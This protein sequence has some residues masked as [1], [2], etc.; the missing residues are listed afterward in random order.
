MATIVVFHSALGLT[1]GTREWAAA[2]AAR[3]AAAGHTVTTPDL[4]EGRTFADVDEAVEFVDGYGLPHWVRVAADA[5]A[6]LTGPRIYVGF[7]FGAA[8][9]QVLALTNPDAAGLVLLSGAMAPSWFEIETWPA[10]L[11]GELHYATLDPWM[12]AEETEALLE[13]A[14][15]ALEVFE[16]EGARHLF[17][18]SDYREFDAEP[19]AELLDRVA[20]HL[21]TA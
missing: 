5:T 6:G 4:F 7:S 14:D 3:T 11:K 17:A 9:A 19:A 10:G 8:L 18:F 21:G 15:G 16:Y 12:E 20:A 1:G 2:L 13:L